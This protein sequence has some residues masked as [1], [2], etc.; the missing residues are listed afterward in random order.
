MK[1]RY[2]GDEMKFSKACG[3]AVLLWSVSV[4]VQSASFQVGDALTAEPVSVDFESMGVGYFPAPTYTQNGI[5]VK[6][7]DGIHTNLITLDGQR[8]WAAA[9]IFDCGPSCGPNYTAG[10]LG[11][12]EITKQD[13]SD[14]FNVSLML[15]SGLFDPGDPLSLDYWFELYDDDVKLGDSYKYSSLD[16]GFWFSV[17][18]G[19]FDKIRLSVYDPDWVASDDKEYNYLVIDNIKA[20]NVPLPATIWLFISGIAGFVAS[21]SFNRR[22]IDRLA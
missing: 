11:Y 6:A 7:S 19:G 9:R 20:S 2:L 18:G 10:S 4:G 5:T 13:G 12:T 14:F 8:S 22:S 21:K 15:G 1:Q 17:L 16:Q 3:F